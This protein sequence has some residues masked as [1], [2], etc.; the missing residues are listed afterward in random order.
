MGN[1]H[2]I[3]YYDDKILRKAVKKVGGK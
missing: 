2:T 3:K 1:N